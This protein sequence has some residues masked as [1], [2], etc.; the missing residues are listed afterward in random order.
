M[1]GILRIITAIALVFALAEWQYDY[2]TLLRVITCVTGI[3]GTLKYFDK[4]QKSLSV[5]FGIVALLFNPIFP[6]YLE[7]VTWAFIDI[8]GAVFI[9]FSL[10]H[11]KKN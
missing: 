10:W 3:W 7:R 11:D 5:G 8:G 6:I 2:Y 4:E 1:F 9:L